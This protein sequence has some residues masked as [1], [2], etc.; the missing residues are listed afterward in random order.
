[1]INNSLS[2]GAEGSSPADRGMVTCKRPGCGEPVPATTRGRSRQ[3]C[4]NECARRYHNDARGSSRRPVPVDGDD[5]LSSLEALLS[6]AMTHLRLI[7]E[8]A[9][10]LDIAQMRAQLAEAEALR[11]RAE[12][13]AAAAATDLAAARQDARAARADAERYARERD[14]ARAALV[15]RMPTG[16]TPTGEGHREQARPCS[17]DPPA[18][19]ARGR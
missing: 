6:R 11:A 15:Q 3:F 8:Q 4:S 10:S 9:A 19:T 5:P 13:D 1:M 7:R 16:R 17:C 12:A 2:G 14:T 18:G